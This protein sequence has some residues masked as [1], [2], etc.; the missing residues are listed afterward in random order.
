MSQSKPLPPSSWL[1]QLVFPLAA[2]SWLETDTPGF[3][4]WSQHA[5]SHRTLSRSFHF[6]YF[7]SFS[8]SLFMKIEMSTLWESCA[9][10]QKIPIG[11]WHR[12]SRNESRAIFPGRRH[13][14]CVKPTRCHMCPQTDSPRSSLG[15][16]SVQAGSRK[17][18][19]HVLKKSSLQNKVAHPHCQLGW[20]RIRRHSS[21]FVCGNVSRE[22]P[23]GRR[24]DWMK[25]GFWDWIRRKEERA[26]QEYRHLSASWCWFTR[27][28]PATVPS[29][30]RWSGPS[31]RQ[32]RFFLPL[33]SSFLSNTF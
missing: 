23:W 1:P 16:S 6:Y 18:T 24:T 19:D 14:D 31:G 21:V 10:I 22:L 13:L 20:I 7:L 29:L 8:L 32:N 4:L 17:S 28:D 33:W 9:I 25:A 5:A 2:E 3:E 12:H 26:S 27:S 15:N 30:L 11:S